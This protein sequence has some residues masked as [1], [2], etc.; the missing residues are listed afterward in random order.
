MSKEAVMISD[1]KK[2]IQL[3]KNKYKNMSMSDETAMKIVRLNTLNSV[4]K[5]ATGVVGLVTVIDYFIPDPVLGLDE[6][7][8]TAITGLLGY[9][10]SLVDNKIDKIAASDDAEL[11][12]EEIN[13]LANKLNDVAGK[14]KNQTPDTPHWHSW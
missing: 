10:S 4:L 2:K 3:V 8:L 13:N 14:V 5:V 6:V 12:M 1:N 7:A 11:K 9:S